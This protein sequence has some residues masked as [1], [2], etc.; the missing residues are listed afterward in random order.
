MRVTKRL[1]GAEGRK[2]QL[3]RRLK[4]CSRRR[5]DLEGSE[6][7]DGQGPIET[8]DKQ[9]TMLSS[10]G[11]AARVRRIVGEHGRLVL[12]R[13]TGCHFPRRAERG[14]RQAARISLTFLAE[15][16]LPAD[17]SIE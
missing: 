12:P 13:Q 8:R 1:V 2:E 15:R 3:D 17:R 4:R 11:K 14:E 6:H 5:R 9:T 7:M 16:E 10:Q